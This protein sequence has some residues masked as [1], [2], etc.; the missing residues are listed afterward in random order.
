MKKSI[1]WRVIYPFW[2]SQ[3]RYSAWA[4]LAFTVI[5]GQGFVGFNVWMNDWH[6]GL[7]DALGARD[8]SAFFAR[9][10]L[11]IPLML[12]TVVVSLL[13]TVLGAI[14][15]FRWRRWVVDNLIEQWLKDGVF[16]R[17]ERQSLADN[18]DQRISEDAEKLVTLTTRLAMNLLT[19]VTSVVSFGVVLWQLSGS[20]TFQLADTLWV[21]PGFMFWLA[22]LYVVLG[23]TLT[24]WV[25]KRLVPINFR[26]ERVEAD[27][28]FQM[29]RIRENA[30]QIALYQG[31]ATERERL[32]AAYRDI[33][34]NW[35]DLL[36]VGTRMNV[37]VMT[38]SELS[39]VVA[40][41]AAA[42]AYFADEISL[43][44]ISRLTGAFTAMQVSLS[45]FVLSY[46]TIVEWKAT[47]NRLTGFINAVNALPERGV[48]VLSSDGDALVTAGLHLH[49]PDGQV[50]G[51]PQALNVH[52]GERWLLRGASGTGKSTLLK[53]LAG[54]WPHGEGLVYLPHSARLLFL[55]QQSYLPEGTLKSVICYPGDEQ[56]FS[57]AQCRTALQTCRLDKLVDSLNLQQ[58]WHQQLSM[59]EQQR[60]AFVRALLHRPDFLFL[61]EATSALDIATEAWLYQALINELPGAAILSV[62]HRETVAQFHDHCVQIEC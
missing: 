37:V 44:D 49:L 15:A 9:L 10:A 39:S 6:G 33:R 26:K 43:G 11:F 17:I 13:N 27:Y 22:V 12:G 30:A 55:P 38:Y 20:V 5:V 53:A 52:R 34:C 32:D 7:F 46:A 14:L 50:L 29:M 61:D 28:R 45:W 18:P 62:A 2:V 57:D 21:I 8:E 41:L 54:L 48:R 35:W 25:G 16:Y 60:L 59:G 19:S 40:Q 4:L 51:R 31:G 24:H 58:P 36:R 42:P 1:A 47:V 23:S 56:D 3:Q